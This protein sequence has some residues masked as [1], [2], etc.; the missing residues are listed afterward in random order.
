MGTINN[1]G[2]RKKGVV[3]VLSPHPDDLELSTTIL[4][5]KLKKNY[6]IL[7]IIFTDGA[8]GGKNKKDFQSQ[9]HIKRRSAEAKRAAKIIGIEKIFFLNF[10]DGKLTEFIEKAKTEAFSILLKNNPTLICFPSSKDKHPDHQATNKIANDYLEKE[11]QTKDMQYCFWG[12]DKREN[13]IIKLN[14]PSKTKIKAVS[15][16]ES[17]PINKY[18]ENNPNIFIEESFYSK[19][20]FEF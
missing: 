11:P 13:K 15:A 18:I 14:K 1:R 4:C 3:I 9:D 16:H 10:P 19:N 2:N 6:R 12:N 17:Q 5:N 7:E 20:N 8:A